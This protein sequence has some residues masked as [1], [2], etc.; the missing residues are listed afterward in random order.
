[1]TRRRELLELAGGIAALAGIWLGIHAF[2]S[3]VILHAYFAAPT[4]ANPAGGAVYSNLVASL[5]C[6]VV[7][8]WRLRTRMIAH[9]VQQLA[10]NARH[11]EEKMAQADT[12]HKALIEHVTKAV[13]GGTQ[14]SRGPLQ[15]KLADPGKRRQV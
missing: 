3:A 1:M 4:A 14:D 8:W 10:Q 6:A 11:H 5:V 2:V 12:H 7:V 15:R 13:N 9:H